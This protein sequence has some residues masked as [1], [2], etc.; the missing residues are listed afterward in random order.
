[1]TTTTAKK[2]S[3]ST[4]WVSH[5]NQFPRGQMFAAHPSRC[6]AS[7]EADNTLEDLQRVY[8]HHRANLFAFLIGSMRQ[9]ALL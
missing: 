8:F 3:H 9:S 2:A 4:A 1:M 6:L 5:L 7:P